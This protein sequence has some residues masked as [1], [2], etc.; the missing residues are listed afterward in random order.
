MDLSKLLIIQRINLAINLN[1]SS[2]TLT[3]LADDDTFSVLWWVKRNPN[4]P[5]YIKDYLNA[6]FFLGNYH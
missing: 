3:I 5:Q 6:R 4:T 1:T 2:E